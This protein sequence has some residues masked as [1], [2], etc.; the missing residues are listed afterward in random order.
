MT[1]NPTLLAVLLEDRGLNRYGSFS[2]AYQKAARALDP[3]LPA[4]A[5]SRAQF[6]RWTKGELRSLP[7]T[8]HCR[9][10]EHMLDGYSATQLLGPCPDREIPAPAR[11]NGAKSAHGANPTSTTLP[12]VT[13]MAGV[14]A[15]FASRSEFAAR[16]E[17]QGLLEGVSS[18]RAAGLSLNLICQ[19][20]PDQFL[21]RL[22]AEGAQLT[23]LFL[24]PDGDAMRERER[25][26]RYEPGI[27]A[28]LTRLNIEM[29]TR[30]RDRLPPAASDR[31]H[32]AAYDETIR[33]NITLAGD[34]TAVVQ[35]YLPHARG[36]E[37]P[38]LLIRATSG[39]GG[40]YPVFEQVYEALAE[41]SRPL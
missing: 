15:I 25:E 13:G 39:A 9:V 4:S 11:G 6:H 3:R 5:P 17:P 22:L 27:L 10:L 32:L 23:C 31:L 18:V 40:L 24:D 21:L 34:H 14:E 2:A 26:E 30:L 1:G 8:D 41:R 12:P 19:Q 20:L 33:F 36:V 7:Y 16:V 35:P 38:T 29:M 28:T 37:S